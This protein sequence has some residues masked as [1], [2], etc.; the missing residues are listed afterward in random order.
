MKTKTVLAYSDLKVTKVERIIETGSVLITLQFFVGGKQTSIRCKLND[1]QQE[2]NRAGYPIANNQTGKLFDYI[3]QQ[4]NKIN[5][6]S[7]HKGIGWFDLDGYLVFRGQKAIGEK[8]SYSGNFSIAPNGNLLD[9]RSDYNNSIYENIPLESSMIMGLSACV[10]GYL[11]IVSEIPVPSLIF[12]IN[13]RSTTGKST[14][15]KLSVSMGGALKEPNKISLSATCSTTANALY[16]ILNDNFGYPMLFDETAR[17][18]K[19]HNYTEMIYSISDGTDKARMTKNGDISAVKHWATAVLFTGES[20]LLS[21]ADTADGLLVRVIPLCNIK[22]TKN[23][24]QAHK[25]EEFSAKYAG[26]PIWHLAKYIYSIHNSNN[27]INTYKYEIN[28]LTEVIP[29]DD[30]YKERT[31]KSIAILSLTTL[32]TEKALKIKFHKNEILEFFLNS[33][34]T[35][36]PE[37][38]SE[39][40]FEYILNKYHENASKFIHTS[41]GNTG[42]FEGVPKDCFGKVRLNYSKKSFRNGQSVDLLIILRE[43]FIEW[44]NQGGFTNHDNI[45]REWANDELICRQKEDRFYSGLILKKGAP[46]SICI[47]IVFSAE[48]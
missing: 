45:L 39:R 16:G 24:E 48:E 46:P 2:L 38:E 4:M 13:G 27:I 28:R 10:T 11:A 40:A 1:L 30:E 29:L 34:E 33:I 35:S 12:D 18:G 8:S 31:A 6:E 26:L 44:L 43:V 41:R 20:P 5:A 14:S 19:S 37:T 25:V 9:F 17:F 7:I 47:R 21:K 15:A 3:H 32:L 22:W 23:A 42:L 36:S